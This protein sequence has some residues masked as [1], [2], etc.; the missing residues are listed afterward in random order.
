MYDHI[1]LND[2][3]HDVTLTDRLIP[4]M[5]AGVKAGAVAAFYNDVPEIL[6]LSFV[7]FGGVSVFYETLRAFVMPRWEW[8]SERDLR[9][10][11]IMALDQILSGD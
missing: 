3:I 10:L 7:A 2:R 4:L 5:Y 8:A 6:E 11:E 1:S 9:P